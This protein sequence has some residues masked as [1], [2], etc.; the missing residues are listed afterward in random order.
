MA[1][2]GV[3]NLL[4]ERRAD[5]VRDPGRYFLSIFGAPSDDVWGWRL[6]GHHVNLNYTIAAGEIVSATPLFLGAN[7]A[8]VSHGDT[9]VLRP[10]AEEEDAGRALLESLDPGQRETAVICDVRSEEHTSELQSLL[11]N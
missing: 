6:E 8:E 2:E 10:C 9:P 3:L 5:A 7:P 4:E 1:L 11:R